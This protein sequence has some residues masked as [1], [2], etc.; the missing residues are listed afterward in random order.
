VGE[1][2]LSIKWSNIV[3]GKDV[4]RVVGGRMVGMEGKKKKE[5]V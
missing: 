1:C 4:M 2:N 5:N 3:T